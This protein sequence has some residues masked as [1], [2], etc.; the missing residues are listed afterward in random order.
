[1]TYSL[2][3]VAPS[4]YADIKRRIQSAYVELSDSRPYF[5]NSN[6]GEVIVFHGPTAVGLVAAMEE[7]A[8]YGWVCTGPDGNWHWSETK[9]THE[10]VEDVRPATGAEKFFA[11]P[12]K[13]DFWGAGEADCP[14]EIKAPN[15]ELHTLRCK[16][17]GQDSPKDAR[18]FG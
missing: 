14:R 3:E 11:N 13:H 6:K 17:C 4:T 12:S 16:N 10:L 9:P 5:Y 1:M 2:L 8:R 15:G 18:C 7:E